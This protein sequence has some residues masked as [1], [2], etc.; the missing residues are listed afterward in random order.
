MTDPAERM[1]RVRD[2]IAQQHAKLPAH[3][4]D[5]HHDGGLSRFYVDNQPEAQQL[6]YVDLTA[7]TY[8]ADRGDQPH[9]TV[10]MYN[11]ANQTS[12]AAHQQA[13]ATARRPKPDPSQGGRGAGVVDS[14]EIAAREGRTVDALSMLNRR[15]FH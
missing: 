3:S 1:R 13:P 15:I 10:N 11:A 4:S 9:E 8:G 14:P 12:T 5:G 6:D 7:Q 2:T